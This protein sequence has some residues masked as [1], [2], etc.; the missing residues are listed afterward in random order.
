MPT[1]KSAGNDT[2][3]YMRDPDFW[4]DGARRPF[5]ELVEDLTTPVPASIIQRL[6]AIREKSKDELTP[7]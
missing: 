5:H 1:D 4:K 3:D 6:K 7:N 2:Y